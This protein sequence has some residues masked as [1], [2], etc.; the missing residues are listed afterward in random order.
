MTIKK[1]G[2]CGAGTMGGGCGIAY[3]AAASGFEVVLYGDEQR[4]V[5]TAVRHLNGLFD[6]KIS[7]QKMTAEDKAALLQRMTF[8]TDIEEFASV[9][10]VLETIY[11]D[12][13]VKKNA[14]ERLD[15]ICRPEVI[16]A[17]NCVNISITDMAAITERSEKVLGLKFVNPP[18]VMRKV[19]VILGHHTSNETIIQA[20]QFILAMGKKPVL[21]G[22]EALQLSTEGH[23]VLDIKTGQRK[24][25]S[26]YKSPYE[27]EGVYTEAKAIL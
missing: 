9:D 13:E 4:F 1:I 14:L 22:G 5:D 10:L 23:E 12:I 21:F 15:K 11:D 8:T 7:L 27:Y 24:S 18:Q 16:F 25:L 26:Q 6:R 3:L 19:E 20:S 2:I 17:S